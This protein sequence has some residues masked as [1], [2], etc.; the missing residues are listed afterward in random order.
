MPSSSHHAV[1]WCLLG[2]RQRELSKIEDLALLERLD[3]ETDELL[4]QASG[5][6]SP[7]AINDD[8]ATTHTDIVALVQRAHQAARKA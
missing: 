3:E 6:A 5:G 1:C 2:A 4:H 7:S 8:P